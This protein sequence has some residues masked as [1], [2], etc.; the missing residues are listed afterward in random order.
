MRT[1]VGQ[2]ELDLDAGVEEY[3]IVDPDRASVRVVRRGVEDVVTST[4]LS[5]SPSG[6]PAELVIRVP[7]LFNRPSARSDSILTRQ[8]NE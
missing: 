4:E 5:W 6:A 3:W 8:R 2:R 7:T 1:S